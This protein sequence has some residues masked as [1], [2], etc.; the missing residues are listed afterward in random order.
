MCAAGMCHILHHE[1]H[2]VL[3]LPGLSS[4]DGLRVYREH[5]AEFAGMRSLDLRYSR[6]DIASAIKRLGRFDMSSRRGR[7]TPSYI[8]QQSVL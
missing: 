6:I 7:L 2:W 1:N 5:M 3:G 4:W 8:V